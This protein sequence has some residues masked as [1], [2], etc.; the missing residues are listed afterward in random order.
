MEARKEKNVV[1]MTEIEQILDAMWGELLQ[2]HSY[3]E[4][5]LMR[6]DAAERIARQLNEVAAQQ[7]VAR[8]VDDLRSDNWAHTFKIN[9]EEGE[10]G[11]T[12]AEW[13]HK[14]FA[15]NRPSFIEVDLYNN[16]SDTMEIGSSYVSIMLY[17]GRDEWFEE[18]IDFDDLDTWEPPTDFTSFAR[19]DLALIGRL[20]EDELIEL[21]ATDPVTAVC[22][23]NA[24]PEVFRAAGA[25]I[26]VNRW[27]EVSIKLA[28]R[29]VIVGAVDVTAPVAE[30]INQIRRLGP[31]S[32][33]VRSSIDVT[34]THVFV[35]FDTGD[36]EVA[37][38][39][40]GVRCIGN[41]DTFN[42]D[43]AKREATRLVNEAGLP[44]HGRW[45]QGHDSCWA[46]LSVDVNIS[47]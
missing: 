31:F 9:L 10:E 1:D 16:P 39:G 32:I 40:W 2:E 41:I 47:K 13:G 24:T 44:K 21:A 28:D 38:N 3:S 14:R 35:D 23:P 15:D 29:D 27:G 20:S 11:L 8:I 42:I 45:G 6:V 34:V 30:V 7:E 12:I 36:V 25:S 4:V 37:E 26:N 22:A 17:M 5:C 33:F 46:L 43:D 19:K 18:Y